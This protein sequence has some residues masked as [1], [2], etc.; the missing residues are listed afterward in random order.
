M[1]DFDKQEK[2]EFDDCF[3]IIELKEPVKDSKNVEITQIKFPTKPKFKQVIK[4]GNLYNADYSTNYDALIGY[5][6]DLC[7]IHE[8]AEK[9]LT[10]EVFETF[11]IPDINRVVMKLG[12]WIGRTT[13]KN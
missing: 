1:S 3:L 9:P 7:K 12:V 8:E 13:L 10:I 2:D 5:V 4:Y 6:T 11:S